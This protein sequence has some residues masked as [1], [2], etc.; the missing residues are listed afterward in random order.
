MMSMKR[1]GKITGIGLPSHIHNTV[2]E[3]LDNNKLVVHLFPLLLLNHFLV[4]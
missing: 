1:T 3:F 2:P 4:G